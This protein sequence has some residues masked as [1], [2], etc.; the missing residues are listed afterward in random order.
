ML[1]QAGVSLLNKDNEH[2]L[3]GIINFDIKL[4]CCQI[5]SCQRTSGL[6]SCSLGG[7]NAKAMSEPTAPQFRRSLL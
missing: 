7:C 5:S 2:R 4:E 3:V 1:D 6:A